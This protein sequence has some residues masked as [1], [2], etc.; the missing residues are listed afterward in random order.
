VSIDSPCLQVMRSLVL[1]LSSLALTSATLGFDAEQA[2]SSPT[3]SCLK[4]NG[5]SF[6][7]SR[8]YR[9]NGALDSTGVQNIKNAWSSGGSSAQFSEEW[10]DED[11]NDL[12]RCRDIQLGDKPEYEQ[13]VHP[14]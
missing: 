11:R 13:T 7:I 10:R 2:I 9:S 14:R 12:A 4:S 6:Y 8:I 3:F 1:L 5:Y